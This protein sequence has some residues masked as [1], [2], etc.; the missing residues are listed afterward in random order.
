MNARRSWA[1]IPSLRPSVAALS[2]T[3]WVL[4]A[5][6][7]AGTASAQLTPVS[8][9][10]LVEPESVTVGEEFTLTLSVTHPQDHHIAFPQLPAA[11]GEFEIR[12]QTALPTTDDGDGKV[13]SS[14]AIRAA[15]FSPGQHPT[16]A[17][18]VAVRRP[19]GSVVNRPVRPVEVSVESVLSAADREMREIK[20]QVDVQ[21]PTIWPFAYGV[22][23]ALL[24]AGLAAAY[25]W[26]HKLLPTSVIAHRDR[27]SPAARA[28][29]E[30]D[31]I[32]RL[33]LPSERRFK[34]HY[35]LVSDCLRVYMRG[36]FGILTQEMTTI[37]ITEELEAA[38]ITASDIRDVSGILGE[39][40]LVKFARLLPVPEEAAETV[41]E[42]RRVVREMTPAE[43]STASGGHRATSGGDA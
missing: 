3:T 26:R 16:P 42:S 1:V 4:A 14:I 38:P 17:L 22:T 19:D 7:A 29:G 6:L 5:V 43:A 23:A 31:R 21:V 20:P 37:Q 27:R 32:E 15:L 2:V 30:L 28:L 10:L 39:S 12:G 25:F 11:W 35:T 33:D 9:G 34:E 36:Q 13:R 24:L 8:V 41:N 18:S 40:D